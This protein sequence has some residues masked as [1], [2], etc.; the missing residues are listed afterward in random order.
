QL[1]DVITRKQSLELTIDKVDEIKNKV[2]EIVDKVNLRESEI[3][4]TS[5]SLEAQINVLSQKE[6]DLT[7]QIAKLKDKIIDLE[8]LYLNV[9]EKDKGVVESFNNVKSNEKL[10]ESFSEKVHLRDKRLEE[11]ESKTS[12][13][14]GKLVEFQREQEDFLKEVSKL[15]ESAKQALQYSTAEGLS[16]SFQTRLALI[17]KKPLGWW[18]AGASI[19]LFA[20][21]GLGVWIVLDSQTKDIG[22]VISRITLIPL[23][24][25]GS[26]FCA[27]QYVRSQN[28]IEDYAY[29]VALSKSLVGF[30]EQIKKHGKETNDEYMNYITMV[31]KE[32]HKDPLR[33]RKARNESNVSQPDIDYSA[34][35][36]EFLTKS[37]K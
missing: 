19:C 29:K 3:S 25:T 20:A 32:I 13:Y 30:S 24:I 28:I 4:L 6:I 23:L 15:V 9:S 14:I 37:P 22:I 21:T 27:N 35:V 5:E 26:V 33:G 16:A 10:I 18:L 12:D 31:L 17:E 2:D 36:R 11:I 1:D 34:L 8:G 7:S